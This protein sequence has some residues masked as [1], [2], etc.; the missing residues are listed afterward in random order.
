MATESWQSS[1]SILAFFNKKRRLSISLYQNNFKYIALIFTL[2]KGHKCNRLFEVTPK[3]VLKGD[4]ENKLQ[5]LRI[6]QNEIFNIWR[7]DLCFLNSCEIW[8]L[9]SLITFWCK[10]LFPWVSCWNQE[11]STLINRLLDV[12]KRENWEYILKLKNRKS[13]LI[14]VIKFNLKKA[15]VHRKRNCLWLYAPVLCINATDQQCCISPA[16]SP[17]AF[18][19]SCVFLRHELKQGTLTFCSLWQ[20][21]EKFPLPLLF[22]STFISPAREVDVLLPRC[23]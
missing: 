1:F 11:P 2:F 19:S 10:V 23:N 14:F 6:S 21:K 7:F 17:G 12:T 18:Q 13:L 9:F 3:T 5:K 8:D 4:G 22:S 16:A 20:N 15:G